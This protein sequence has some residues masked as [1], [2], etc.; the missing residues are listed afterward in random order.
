MKTKLNRSLLLMIVILQ[1]Q[2]Y[3]QQVESLIFHLKDRGAPVRQ[4][5]PF[6]AATENVCTGAA[7]NNVRINCWRQDIYD[8]DVVEYHS[9]V[10][11]WSLRTVCSG[12][13][14]VTLQPSTTLP[15][16]E[17]RCLITADLALTSCA[18]D[19]RSLLSQQH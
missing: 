9:S 7:I 11:S 13:P 16:T 6:T 4:I 19:F 12:L 3:Q 18:D 5:F 1:N 2:I 14:F 10:W 17:I 8:Y 15:D